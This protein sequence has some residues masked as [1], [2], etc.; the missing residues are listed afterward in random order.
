[1]SVVAGLAPAFGTGQSSKLT[2]LYDNYGL[3]EG[4]QADWGFACLVE[5]MEKT[6]LFDAGTKPEVLKHNVETLN[7]SLKQVQQIV[8]SHAHR[9]H[10]GGL[11]Y[12]MGQVKNVEIFVP[13]SFP[14]V[15]AQAL[16]QRGAV[17]TRVLQ[18]REICPKVHLTG[19]MG[20][21]IKEQSLLL[22][23][24]D[25]I[26]VITGCSHQGTVEII[27]RSREIID[28][29]IS[30]IFGGF[31]LNRHSEAQIVEIIDF[32]SRSGVQRCGPTHCTGDKAI[33]MFKEAYGNDFVPMGV[34]KIIEIR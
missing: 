6:V 18:P 14:D 31:H 30:L 16:S 4:T 13:D 15:E 11:D 8:I 33:M 3:V 34:G 25:G 5:G 17:V 22:D 28:K 19:E 29:Q 20:D 32:F 26:Y 9:D 27:K 2:V 23:T 21:Q 10:T 1:M 7:V 24:P 12:V